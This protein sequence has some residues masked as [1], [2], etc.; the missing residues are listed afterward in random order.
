MTQQQR[1]PPEAYFP[2]YVDEDAELRYCYEKCRCGWATEDLK[3]PAQA[4]HRGD[5]HGEYGRTADCS[6]TET[7]LRF[8][9]GTEA[10]I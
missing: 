2:D 1:D 10:R 7:V 3:H 8:E 5:L 9:D 6:L 4:R